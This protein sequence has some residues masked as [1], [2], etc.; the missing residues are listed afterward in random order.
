MIT[1]DL[2]DCLHFA[3]ARRVLLQILDISGALDRHFCDNPQTMAF[4]E[5][6]RD[7]GIELLTALETAEQ[8]SVGGLIAESAAAKR[9]TGE[10]GN[11]TR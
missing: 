10:A 2:R 4:L 11:G 7:M 8:G 9:K 3:P 1:D 5:G 6:R